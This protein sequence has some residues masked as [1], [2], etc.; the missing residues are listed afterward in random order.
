MRAFDV[1]DRVRLVNGG[2]IGTVRRAQLGDPTRVRM[3]EVELDRDP[4]GK[5]TR[6]PSSWLRVATSRDE[7]TT[8]R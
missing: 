7:R 3:I 2:G 4:P 5:T 1:G 8:R 6:F